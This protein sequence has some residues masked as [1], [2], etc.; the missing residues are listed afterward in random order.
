[1][2]SLVLLVSFLAFITYVIFIEKI[3]RRKYESLFIDV[4]MFLVTSL[5]FAGSLVGMSIAF[6]S[7]VLFSIY[8]FFFEPKWIKKLI[9]GKR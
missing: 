3:K 4:L 2:L 6:V 7:S 1:M 5:L 9:K 8:L